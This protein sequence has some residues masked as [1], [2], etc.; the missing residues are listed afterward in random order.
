METNSRRDC[1][2]LPTSVENLITDFDLS[3]C[4]VT[5]QARD[6]LK[7]CLNSL[8]ENT[9]SLTYEI[10]VTDN[11]S[12]DGTR[13]ML[14]TQFLAIRLIENQKN[15]GFSRPMNQ[16]LQAAQG[17]Y[18]LLLNPDTIILPHAFDMMVAF[19]ETHPQVGICGPK[20]LNS[21]RTLQKSCRRGESRPWAVI[22]YFTGLGKL[23]P[24]SR[25]FGEYLMSYKDEDESSEVAGVAGSCMLVRRKVVDMIGYLDDRFFAYQEDAD[26]CFRARTAGW[27]IFYFPE[28]E[29]IHFGG[30][31][32][33]RVH[34][35]RSIFEWH[36]SYWLYYR[37]NLARD[38]FFILN[39]LYYLLMVLKLILALLVNFFRRDK[40][41]GPKR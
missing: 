11:G 15:L 32:G 26:Y 13:E 2:S 38:Y 40:F 8:V 27:Q 30:Q 19:M 1:E 3:V 33:S 5:Y 24:G 4:I 17:K 14:A 37:K 41:A 34:P 18:L 6:L 21:D 31:G 29:I 25:L 28:S 36:K 10:I 7:D 20:V 16:S 23:F 22:S 12:E 35:Y 39:G 9:H